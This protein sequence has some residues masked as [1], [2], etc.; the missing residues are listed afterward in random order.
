MRRIAPI[1]LLAALFVAAPAHAA[2]TIDVPKL[3]AKQ[4]RAAKQRT[5]VPIL[6][7]QTFRSEF[8]RHFPE[9]EAHAGRW[10]FD[11]G[12]VR[13]CG[14]ATACFIAEFRAVRGGRP[15]GRRTLKLARGRTGFFRPLS[16]GASCSPPSIEWRERG[17]LYGIQANV[18]GRRTERRRLVALANSAIRHGPR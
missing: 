9:G 2:Q 3:F 17:T 12:A 15:S 1:C 10:T 18:G 5:S 14:A 8:R 7:P 4:I 6:L 11:I 16:C 13:D